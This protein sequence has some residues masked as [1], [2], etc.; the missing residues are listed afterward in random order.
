MTEEIFRKYLDAKKRNLPIVNERWVEDSA[1]NWKN[2]AKEKYFEREIKVKSVP[3]RLPQESK[4][5]AEDPILKRDDIALM[6][7]EVDAEMEGLDDE[8]EDE[9]EEDNPYV[10]Q[11]N[12]DEEGNRKR[13][14]GDEEDDNEE[15]GD[16]SSTKQ[17]RL[18]NESDE[19]SEDEMAADLENLL[20]N[21]S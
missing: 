21:I 5:M 12:E 10:E 1:V 18:D 13:N 7:A 20:G 14:L 4:E 3:C 17:A 11:S 2:M 8:E 16:E 9:P 15:D 6:D 19:S